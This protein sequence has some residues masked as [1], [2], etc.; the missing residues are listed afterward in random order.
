MAIKRRR[1][2][3]TFAKI[4]DLVRSRKVGAREA[5]DGQIVGIKASSVVVRDDAGRDWVREWRD[6]EARA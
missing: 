2:N 5:F 6:L 1:V 3:Y 4:G